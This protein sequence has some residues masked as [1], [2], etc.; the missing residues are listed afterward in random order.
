MRVQLLP[1]QYSTNV[2]RGESPTAT[3]LVMVG[4]ATPNSSLGIEDGGCGVSV[5]D[6]ENV[7]AAEGATV[8]TAPPT[9][10]TETNT[11]RYA[12]SSDMV[13][14]AAA[15]GLSSA[16]GPAGR[17]PHKPVIL[18]QHEDRS[19]RKPNPADRNGDPYGQDA[20]RAC[21]ATILAHN[22]LGGT[23]CSNR[24]KDRTDRRCAIQQ[25]PK[26]TPRT[27]ERHVAKGRPV[28]I[29][30]SVTGTRSLTGET[31]AGRRHQPSKSQAVRTAGTATLPGPAQVSRRQVAHVAH[32]FEDGPNIDRCFALRGLRRTLCVASWVPWRHDLILRSVVNGRFGVHA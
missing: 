13:L 16:E 12:R 2:P 9:R 22:P 30:T 23:P 24:R 10:T 20:R 32:Y 4:Q 1:F 31:V 21:P 8:T 26:P 3:Q 28:L 14:T 19:E 27:D 7:A 6:H 5:T 18:R 17:R 11:R 25:S 29:Y 15:S